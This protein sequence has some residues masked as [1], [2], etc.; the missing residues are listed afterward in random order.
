GSSAEIAISNPRFDSSYEVGV[1]LGAPLRTVRLDWVTSAPP[2]FENH[3]VH[4]PARSF[5]IGKF[6]V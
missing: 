2:S 3:S 1:F 6:E 5:S 4:Q